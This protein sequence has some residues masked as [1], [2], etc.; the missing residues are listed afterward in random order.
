MRILYNSKADENFDNLWPHKSKWC[1]I[2]NSNYIEFCFLVMNMS[3]SLSI[4]LDSNPSRLSCYT[5]YGFYVIWDVLDKIKW[6]HLL[7]RTIP[8][9]ILVFSD[10]IIMQTNWIKSQNKA[11]PLASCPQ[12][13]VRVHKMLK[14]MAQMALENVDLIKYLMCKIY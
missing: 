13:L 11:G 14:L 6:L 3:L 10:I 8:L 9:I 2:N 12:N 1:W 5:D 4:L 7:Q